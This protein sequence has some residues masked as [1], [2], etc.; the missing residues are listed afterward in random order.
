MRHG[1]TVRLA[2]GFR[3]V[4]ALAIALLGFAFTHVLVSG[5]RAAGVT[6]TIPKPDPPPTT[7]AQRTSP[8]PAPPPPQP[9]TQPV[10]PQPPPSPAPSPPPASPP[11]AA[12]APPA[13]TVDSATE[14][15]VRVRRV[16]KQTARHLS[17]RLHASA[18]RLP[19]SNAERE[20]AAVRASGPLVPDATP[21]AS[22]NLMAL[23]LAIA[24]GLPL[25]AVGTALMPAWA[26]PQFV[27]SVVNKRR[28]DIVFAGIAALLSVGVGLLIPLVLT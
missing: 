18:I 28:G 16:R 9:Q 21:R 2:A 24:I 17:E 8:P 11:P 1:S 7:S 20:A 23:V 3:L 10:V 19:R 13:A 5:S 12:P 22:S 26:L 14:R 4:L 15:P 25:I 6:T 27:L